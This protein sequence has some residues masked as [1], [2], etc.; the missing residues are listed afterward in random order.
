VC[1]LLLFFAIISLTPVQIRSIWKLKL[2]TVDPISIVSD[3]N[4]PNSDIIPNALI[5]NS[6]QVIFSF[7]YFAFNALLTAMCLANEW[8]RFS[9]SRKGL[10]VSHNPKLAQRSNYFLSVPY[11]YA[12][13]LM[14]TS[15]ILHWL[16]SESLFV[17]AVEAYDAHMK[18]NPSGDAYNCAF[19]LVAIVSG[20]AVDLFMF[21]SLVGLSLRK[22]PSSMPVAGSNSLA[23]AAACHPKKLKFGGEN[24]GSEQDVGS[25]HEEE[26]DMALLPI[27]WGALPIDNLIGHCSFTSDSVDS[28]EVGKRY[29]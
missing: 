29:Q 12:L 4:W 2:R 1:L 27:Q 5:A 15:A 14:A 28:P 25:E 20:I 8:S 24:Y 13:P 6:P 26:E 11:R 19:S 17:V 3:N 9:M 23:I 16:I 10:R 22:L 21:A 7:L 18:R